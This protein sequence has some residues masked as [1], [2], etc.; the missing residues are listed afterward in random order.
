MFRLEKWYLDCVAADGTA[1]LGYAGRLA[2]G[3]L[4]FPFA[5]TLECPPGGPPVERTVVLGAAPP[6]PEG[7]G[8]RWLCPGLGLD[9]FWTAPRAGPL[10]ARLLETT[11][12]TIDWRAAFPAGPARIRPGLEGAGYAESLGLTIAP[13]R[14]PFRRLRWGRFIGAR[15][16]VVWIDWFGRSRRHWI[17]VDGTLDP[18]A[19]LADQGVD[20][21][22]GLALRWTGGRDLRNR[23]VLALLT[24]QLPAV[25]HR[26]TGRLD[27]MHEHKQL[28]ESTVSTPNGEVDHGWTIH[29]DV[30]W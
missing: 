14:L 15:H 24:D 4:A 25:A 17:Y 10:A 13:W 9:A 7:N 19:R 11:A 12:G 16:S 8:L 23:P 5:S 2:W 21:G 27:R 20:A 28:S 1:W 26:L 3:G 6:R 29:E 30:T 18:G 22:D